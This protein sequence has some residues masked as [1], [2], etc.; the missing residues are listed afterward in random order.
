MTTLA[1]TPA[2]AMVPRRDAQISRVPYL[3]GLDGMRALAVIAVIVYHAN[4][5]WLPGGFLGVEMFFVISGYLITL[6]IIAERERTYTVSLVDFWKRRARRLL[7][8]LFAL[9]FL[10]TVYTALFEPAALGQLRG[11]VIAGVFYS[12]NWYQLVVGLGYTAAFDFAPLRH[13]WSLAVEEQFYLVWPLV[14]ILLL[15]RKGTRKVA[16]VSRWLFIA[17]VVIAVTSALLFHP[18]VIGEPSE[19]PE[20]YWF[21]GDRAISKLDFLYIGTFARA[22]GIL[23]GAAFAMIWRPFAVVRGPLRTKG[24]AFDVVA[25]LALIGFCWMCWNIY[26]VGPDGAADARLFRG[27]LFVSS[28]LTLAMIAAISH[29]GARSNRILGNGVLVWIG[30]RSYGLYL[31]HWPIY[32]A[33]RKLAGNSLTLAEFVFAMALTVVVTELSFRFIETPIRTGQAMRVLRRVRWSPSRSPRRVVGGVAGVALVASLF[34]GTALLTA[35]V[36]QNE[37]A[38]AFEENEAATVDLSSRGASLPDE[39]TDALDRPEPLPD[40]GPAPQASAAETIP[41][42]TRRVEDVPLVPSPR[43]QASEPD[44]DALDADSGPI[45]NDAPTESETPA[46]A[47][48]PATTAAPTTVPPTTTPPTTAPP[49]VQPAAQAGVVADL[50]S[51]PALDV[52]P[53]GPAPQVRVIGFGDSVML[54]S[55]EELTERGVVVDAVQSRQFTAA[56]PEVAAIRDNGFLG[57]AVIVHLGTNGSFSQTSLD[58]MMAI[59]A[60]VPV[61]VFVTGKAD[62]GWIAGNNEKLRALPAAY[63]NVTVLDWAV[64]GGQCDGDCF[65]DDQIHLNG[66]GQQYYADL[67]ARLLGLSTT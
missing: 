33:I 50:S 45:S 49:P 42:T 36:E 6:L 4:S 41:P 11:D 53:Q 39:I 30:V 54:G 22:P 13:L 15:G 44:D 59:L 52:P 43:G 24:T 2:P 48:V 1:P 35:E 25:A 26:L 58:E 8:A 66:R 63:D 65:Y 40:A 60:D 10:V 20:A 14:M 56:I 23:L 46:P 67:V 7:P 16:D 34:A 38:E 31:Y 17:A 9:L 62:R 51:V 28:V 5:D 29:P 64:L 19:T 37:I 3:P 47:A 61:V 32:Q 12:S 18:G 21:I 27:G 55:A 57:S